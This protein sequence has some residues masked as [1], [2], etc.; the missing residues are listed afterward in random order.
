MCRIPERFYTD[1]CPDFESNRMEQVAA[2]IRMRLDY[3]MVGEPRG[4][5]KIKRFFETVNDMF[6]CQL[7]GFCPDGEAPP[8]SGLLS[9]PRFDELFRE[10]L[11][12]TY[13]RRTHGET[14]Q[15]PAQRWE[16]GTFVPRMPDTV[17]RLDLLLL[18]EARPRRVGRDGIRVANRK[19]VDLTLAP[20]IGEDV[21]IRYDPRDIGEIRVYHEGVFLCRAV[22]TDLSGG[23]YSYMEVKE[24][25]AKGRRMLRERKR[26]IEASAGELL[27]LR[28]SSA[29][30]GRT[31]HPEPARA[32]L[33]GDNEKL[34]ERRKRDSSEASPSS[35]KSYRN[36]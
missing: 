34:E 27:A 25:N 30:E 29:P 13:L 19:Y 12:G 32:E 17:E 9:L 36:E 24:M 15:A 31:D 6:L 2:D 5:G 18:T 3:S 21:V 10:W 22:C 23:S 33:H 28:N 1:H 8:K 11:L 14:K 4:R 26:E 20:F 16:A 7:D 35:L